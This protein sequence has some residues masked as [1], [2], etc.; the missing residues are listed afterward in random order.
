M[1]LV[2]REARQRA[3]A[4]DQL[5][6]H[7]EERERVDR[8]DQQ[9]VVGVL[10]VVEVKATEAVLVG[11][12]RHDLLHVGALG[13]MTE[14]DQHAGALAEPAADRDRRSPV[15]DVGGVERRLEEL[16]LDEQLLLRRQRRVELAEALHDSL[17]ALGEVVLTGVVGAV[18]EPQRLGGRAELGRDRHAL[19]QR[20]DR[21]GADRRVGIAD[22]AELVVGIL[23]D[24]GVDGAEA[25]PELGR[26]VAQRT[27]IICRIPG[28]VRRDRRGRASEA[29]H[30][31]GIVEALKN[32]A[33]PTR[34]GEDAKPR[35]GVTK[36]PRR[37]LS[38]PRAAGSPGGRN[39]DWSRSWL[40]LS[41]R[42][43]GR[44]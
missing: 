6:E 44:L 3:A 12:Q 14:V 15:R 16:V 35:A 42:S 21:L 41:N 13:V 2:D 36:T 33:R 11:D 37:R 26:V 27:E 1:R 20:I 17:V 28:E 40:R 25:Q 7:Q 5:G 32:I 18:G 29:M 9:V 39:R 34:L 23:E 31:S 4:E 22:R 24:V 19:D 43:R 10:A 8:A 38:H 30:L